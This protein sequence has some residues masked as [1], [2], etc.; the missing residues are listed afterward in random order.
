MPQ[1]MHFSEEG[2]YDH[3]PMRGEVRRDTRAAR[4]T[5]VFIPIIDAFYI[6][7][8][9]RLRKLKD[10]LS[11]RDCESRFVRPIQRVAAA[12][13]VTLLLA[14]RCRP[15]PLIAK[16]PLCTSQNSDVASFRVAYL[17]IP[18]AGAIARGV[19]GTN[20]PH[21]TFR[22]EFSLAPPFSLGDRPA[23]ARHARGLKSTTGERCASGVGAVALS[24]PASFQLHCHVLTC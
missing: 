15:L 18:I 22:F 23:A 1:S 7:H 24:K 13:P 20:G 12:P 3:A 11:L 9:G 5:R 2:I 6:S 21:S 19:Y 8:A 16:I 10:R 4:V 17:K 14:Y